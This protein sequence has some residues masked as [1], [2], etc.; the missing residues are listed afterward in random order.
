[1]RT[2]TCTPSRTHAH[3]PV[4]QETCRG[5][6]PVGIKVQ[7]SGHGASDSGPPGGGSLDFWDTEPG[8]YK[9]R[10]R[11]KSLKTFSLTPATFRGIWHWRV[12]AIS[13][14]GPVSTPLPAPAPPATCP[15][16]PRGG[17]P[18]HPHPWCLG[19]T[20]SRPCPGTLKQAFLKDSLFS[21]SFI[22]P[23]I[24]PLTHSSG[25][26]F[27]TPLCTRPWTWYLGCKYKE[28][29]SGKSLLSP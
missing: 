13:L 26:Y 23:F 17:C 5:P 6:S 1:M 22:P 15:L 3:C 8:D 28:D 2:Y 27:S 21:H 25:K 18:P 7:A 10:R 11:R 20:M 29:I 16:A 19:P 12:S 9:P 24:Y 4:A 14:S